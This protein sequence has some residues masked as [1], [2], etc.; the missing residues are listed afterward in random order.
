MPVHPLGVWNPARDRLWG[1]GQVPFSLWGLNLPICT[2]EE[3][4]LGEVLGFSLAM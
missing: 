4:R 1:L 2:V 3:I